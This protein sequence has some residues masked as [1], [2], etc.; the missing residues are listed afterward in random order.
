MSPSGETEK[1]PR[2]GEALTS[3]PSGR[4]GQVLHPLGA[5]PAEVGRGEHGSIAGAVDAHQGGAVEAGQGAEAVEGQ[6]LG[7]ERADHRVDLQGRLGQVRA[8]NRQGLRLRR[9]AAEAGREEG[10]TQDPE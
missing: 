7:A 10:Q 8:V 3:R 2:L 6:I 9:F 5:L 1:T 4:F